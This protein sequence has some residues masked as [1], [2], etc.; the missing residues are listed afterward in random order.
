MSYC[1]NNI[2]I[3]E[4]PWVCLTYSAFN[5][6]VINGFFFVLLILKQSIDYGNDWKLLTMWIMEQKISVKFAQTWY[7]CFENIVYAV[8]KLN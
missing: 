7:D 2:Q 4:C 1:Y 6:Y 8:I 3:Y 5:K